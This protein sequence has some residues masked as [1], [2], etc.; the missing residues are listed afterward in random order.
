MTVRIDVATQKSLE[1]IAQYEKRSKS[2][3]AASAISE[4]IAMYEAQV[5]GIERAIVSAEA[6][7]GIPHSGVKAWAKSLGTENELSVPHE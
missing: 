4:Y 7:K 5:K 6:G 2:F 1:K 3:L